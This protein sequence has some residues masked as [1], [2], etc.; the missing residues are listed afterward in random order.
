MARIGVVG[1]G[2]WGTAIA[3]HAV[4]LEHDVRLWAFEPEVAEDVNVRHVNSV[5]LP[6]VGLPAALRASNEP[7]EV[8]D[9]ADLVVLVPPSRH[10]RAIS[11][12][13]APHVPRGALVA[14]ATKG[15]EE[16]S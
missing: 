3:A 5:F 14:V 10:A 13:F 11:T 4:R 12:L 1:A 15:I 6:D 9:R 8:V 2:A 16:S 7:A